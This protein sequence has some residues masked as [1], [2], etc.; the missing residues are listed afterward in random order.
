MKRQIL[1]LLIGM[2][3]GVSVALPLTAMASSWSLPFMASVN[4]QA[5]EGQEDQVQ[6]QEP[7]KTHQQMHQ[8]M[9]AVRGEGTSQRMH[10]AMPGSE[11]MMEECASMMDMMENMEGMMNGMGGMMGNG[12]GTAGKMSYSDTER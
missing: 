2:T 11:E 12:S 6:G 7:S 8:M 9:D 1:M 3:L 10:E 5:Q 4:W